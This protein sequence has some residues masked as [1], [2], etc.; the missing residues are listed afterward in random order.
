LAVQLLAV[1]PAGLGGLH[2]RAPA[3]FAR[4]ALLAVLRD[5]LPPGT[6]WKRV[7]LQIADERLLGGLD[8]AATLKAGRPAVLPCL[9][10]PSAWR[11]KRRRASWPCSIAAKWHWRATG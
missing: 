1:D 8:L 10:W 7:P 11:P 6:P 2:V 9:R 5:L 4:D 3:G